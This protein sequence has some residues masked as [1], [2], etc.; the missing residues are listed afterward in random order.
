MKGNGDRFGR[1]IDAMGYRF[2][3]VRDEIAMGMFKNKNSTRGLEGEG[4]NRKSK[5]DGDFEGLWGDSGMAFKNRRVGRE[6][7]CW[8]MG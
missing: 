8:F 4:I 2:E 7:I 5:M 6:G 1:K 3:P